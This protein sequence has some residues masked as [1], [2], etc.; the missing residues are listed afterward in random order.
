MAPRLNIS[1]IAVFNGGVGGEVERHWLE[2]GVGESSEGENCDIGFGLLW[3]KG[4]E[5]L[6]LFAISAEKSTF[7][8]LPWISET[9]PKHGPNTWKS[10]YILAPGA[11]ADTGQG[12]HGPKPL[13][14]RLSA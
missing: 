11:N 2:I 5:K 4:K 9:V 8:F 7:A 10:T 1:E 6:C 14:G 13:M 12:H 3:G